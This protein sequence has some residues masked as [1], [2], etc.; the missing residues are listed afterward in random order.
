REVILTEESGIGSGLRAV[1]ELIGMRRSAAEEIRAMS[2]RVYFLVGLDLPVD[3]ELQCRVIVRVPLGGVS[4]DRL[5]YRG[6][7]VGR[8]AETFQFPISFELILNDEQ[9]S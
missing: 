9:P 1:K 8:C 5:K 4:Y 7:H 3:Y 2:L 6:R